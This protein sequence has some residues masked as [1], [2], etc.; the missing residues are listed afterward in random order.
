MVLTEDVF[1]QFRVS[2]RQVP[3]TLLS[4]F[5][6][7]SH[8]YKSEDDK[9]LVFKCTLFPHVKTE[10]DFNKTLGTSGTNVTWHS[11]SFFRHCH[12]FTGNSVHISFCQKLFCWWINDQPCL[13]ALIPLGP[14]KNR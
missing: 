7:N 12:T 4:E 14:G 8:S 10:F 3:E 5:L 9:L 2:N 13:A 1:Y 11:R 6:F